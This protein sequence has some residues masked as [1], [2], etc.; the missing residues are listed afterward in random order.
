LDALFHNFLIHEWFDAQTASLAAKV[1]TK[2]I[3][4]SKATTTPPVAAI[5]Q[6]TTADELLFAAV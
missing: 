6:L 3:S 4:A 1:S 2:S 5:F